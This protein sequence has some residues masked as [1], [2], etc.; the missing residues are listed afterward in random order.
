MI[1]KFRI[2]DLREY[3]NYSQEDISNRLNINRRS[4]VEY[5]TQKNAIPI[6]LLLEIAEFYNVSLDYIV[7]IT[8]IKYFNGNRKK[9]KLSQ[10]TKILK[11][12]RLS[13]N[14][15]QKDLANKLSYNHNTISQY[16]TQ[17]RSISVETLISLCKIFNVSLDV[18]VGIKD[19]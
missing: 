9:F 2:K 14:T 18:L 19:K 17:K 5:E 1:K 7:G 13:K 3:Y 15:T 6:S 16:E 4:Y 11:N 12:Y 10:L 8:N